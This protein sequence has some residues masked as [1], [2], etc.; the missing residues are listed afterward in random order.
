MRPQAERQVKVR[1]ALEKIAA[2]EELTASEEE[3]D[4]EYKRISDAYNVPVD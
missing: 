1:L 4:A 2:L 3:I